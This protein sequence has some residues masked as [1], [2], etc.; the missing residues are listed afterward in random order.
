MTCRI[1][2]G[3]FAPGPGGSLPMCYS[4]GTSYDRARMDGTTWSLIVWA[5]GR[6][7]RAERKRIAAREAR[8]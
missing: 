4:C 3:S 5:A 7:R 2:G 6:A 8:P 1:C